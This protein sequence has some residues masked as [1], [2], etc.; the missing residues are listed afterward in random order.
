[1]YFCKVDPHS[2]FLPLPLKGFVGETDGD[3]MGEEGV[4]HLVLIIELVV[5]HLQLF[6]SALHSYS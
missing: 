2:A 6:P 4:Y 3:R 1:M 5:M